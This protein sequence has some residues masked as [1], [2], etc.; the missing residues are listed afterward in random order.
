MKATKLV[1]ELQGFINTYGDL[2]VTLHSVVFKE[3][4]KINDVFRY[5]DIFVGY[6]EYKEE[7]PKIDIRTFP[8]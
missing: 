1:E 6:D 4:A 3:D 8:Y 7:S 5:D 2:D